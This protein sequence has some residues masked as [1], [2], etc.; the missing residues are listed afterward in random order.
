LNAIQFTQPAE[1]LKERAVGQADSKTAKVFHDQSA[2]DIA[3]QGAAGMDL[4]LTPGFGR[5]LPSWRASHP[6]FKS[7]GD[8]LLLDAALNEKLIDTDQLRAQTFIV[9]IAFDRGQRRSEQLLNGKK[10][11]GH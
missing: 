10:L 8:E 4:N 9:N 5:D 6:A 7:R 3:A 11:G 2:R 1:V